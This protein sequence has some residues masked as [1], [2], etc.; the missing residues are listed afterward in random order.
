MKSD[1]TL[2]KKSKSNNLINDK[3]PIVSKYENFVSL[4]PHWLGGDKAPD[5]SPANIELNSRE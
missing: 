5:P 2:M 1:S 3:E 4:S